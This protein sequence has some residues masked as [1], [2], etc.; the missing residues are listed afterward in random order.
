MLL[1]FH[2]F[3]AQSFVLEFRTTAIWQFQI[4]EAFEKNIQDFWEHKHVYEFTR[5]ASTELLTYWIFNAKM[6]EIVDV[7]PSV[8]ERHNVSNNSKNVVKY[9]STTKLPNS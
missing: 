8:K 2:P 6:C 7:T 4:A 3:I 9:A 5:S 1:R